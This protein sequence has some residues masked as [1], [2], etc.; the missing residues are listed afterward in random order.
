MYYAYKFGQATRA[1]LPLWHFVDIFCH[2]NPGYNP[3]QVLIIQ[4]ISIYYEVVS[5]RNTLTE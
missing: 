1:V 2:Q 3:N 4:V 5:I